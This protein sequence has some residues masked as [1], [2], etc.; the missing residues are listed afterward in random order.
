MGGL[1]GLKYN[2]WITFPLRKRRSEIDSKEN[3]FFPLQSCFY[4][5]FIFIF[6]VCE[7]SLEIYYDDDVLK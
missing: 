6:E 1:R 3:V 7:Q 4:F 5:I 2:H